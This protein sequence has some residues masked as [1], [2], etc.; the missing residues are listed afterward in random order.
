MKLDEVTVLIPPPAAVI[1]T[2]PISTKFDCLI[3]AVKVDAL[4]TIPYNDFTSFVE[5]EVTAVET[6]VFSIPSK[7]NFSPTT[8]VPFVLYAVIIPEF[9][10]L[11]FKNPTAPLDLPLM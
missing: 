11:Y 8:N 3:S 4:P 6:L 1:C 2:D 5:Y 9:G 10:A 7:I